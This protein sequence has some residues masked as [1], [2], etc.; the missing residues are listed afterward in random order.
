MSHVFFYS[1]TLILRKTNYHLLLWFSLFWF[2]AERTREFPRER[3]EERRRRES[4]LIHMAQS[5]FI[6]YWSVCV[7]LGGFLYVFLVTVRIHLPRR[8]GMTS[9]LLLFSTTE[10][11]ARLLFPV[12]RVLRYFSF[13]LLICV[14][15]FHSQTLWSDS[16]S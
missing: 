10:A 13:L 14:I 7:Y 12:L 11:L 8:I 2:C 4:C 9:K 5:T 1:T 3:K 6:S 15:F 16:S